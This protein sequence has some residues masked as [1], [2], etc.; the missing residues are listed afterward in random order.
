MDPVRQVS[1]TDTKRQRR[2]IALLTIL[3]S[4]GIALYYGLRGLVPVGKGAAP[5]FAFLTEPRRLPSIAF[6]DATGR[7]L[8]LEQFRGKVVLLNIWATWCTP[9]R[10]EMP[11]LDRLQ[12]QLGGNDFEV[13]ALSIDKGDKGM[14]LVKSFYASLGVSR[15]RVYHDPEGA[16]GFD[17]GVMGVP[18]TLLL[19]REGREIGRMS[20]A[21]EWDSPESV[22][23]MRRY[24]VK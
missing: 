9:C 21:A 18:A 19:D 3:A 20:G 5:T 22:A 15:L 2:V 16:A 1:P 13:V 8:S 24:I 6:V 7:T 11:S 10:Q 4:V 12:E 17:L 14:E 23:L